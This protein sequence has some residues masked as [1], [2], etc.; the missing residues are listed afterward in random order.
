MQFEGFNLHPT[1]DHSQ[2]AG[3]RRRCH[4]P[5]LATMKAS[6]PTLPGVPDY[7]ATVECSGAELHGV[8]ASLRARGATVYSM[9]AICNARWR[10][11]L[12]WPPK[13]FREPVKTPDSARQSCI[14]EPF[15]DRTFQK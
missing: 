10:L 14:R 8:L 4:L 1:G 9:T 2:T 15:Y 3:T 11:N 5:M 12:Q 13:T 7:P 6:Q